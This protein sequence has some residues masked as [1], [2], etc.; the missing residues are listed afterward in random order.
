MI[1]A[2]MLVSGTGHAALIVGETPMPTDNRAGILIED[3][4]WRVSL[5]AIDA[6]S[7]G[8]Y[9]EAYLRWME[10]ARRGDAYA[11]KNIGLLFYYGRGV[12]QD[13]AEA[14]RWYRYAAE[15]GNAGA[16]NDLGVMYALGRGVTRDY[17][18]ALM[19]ASLS[20]A[21]GFEKAQELVA[22]LRARMAARDMR[23]ARRLAHNWLLRHKH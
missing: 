12:S 23:T 1:F 4:T 8:N 7:E 2:L 18:E 5:A 6:Y 13:Y 9:R 22:F 14:A 19:W 16:Q 21:K 10:M 11:Q 15:R 3:E 17:V 20:A